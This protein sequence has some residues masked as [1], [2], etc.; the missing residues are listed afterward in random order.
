MLSPHLSLSWNLSLR[1]PFALIYAHACSL[2][3]VV[4]KHGLK[5]H[6]QEMAGLEDCFCV[7]QS[8]SLSLSRFQLPH[9]AISY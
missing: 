5:F 9:P 6:G 7:M 8:K 2:S 4:K 1:D 3:S